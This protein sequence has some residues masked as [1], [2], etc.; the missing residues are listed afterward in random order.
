MQ[1]EHRDLEWVAAYF[2]LLVRRFV[3]TPLA[4]HHDV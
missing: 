2:A 3:Q 4:H 1:V